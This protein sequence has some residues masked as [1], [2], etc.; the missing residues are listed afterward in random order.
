[1]ALLSGFEVTIDEV[2]VM[3]AASLAAFDARA[4]PAGWSI[5][6]PAQLG[7]GAQY[8]DGNYFKNGNS[9]ASAIVLQKGNEYIVSIRGSDDAADAGQVSKLADGTY[10]NFFKPLLNAVSAAAPTDAHFS[11]T[12]I[13]LGGGAVN[14]LANI[15]ASAYGG[16]FADATFVGFASPII[17]DKSG[18]VNFGFE[19]DPIFKKLG[20]YQSHT[21]SLDNLVLATDEYLAGNYDGRHPYSEDAHYKAQIGFEAIARLSQS[22]FYNRMS[23]DSLVIFAASNGIIQDQAPGRTIG[24]FYLGQDTADRIVGRSGSDFIEGFSGNDTL[25]GGAGNDQI[26]G[27]LGN[28]ALSGGLGIDTLDGG[29][30]NDRLLVT[31]TEAKSDRLFGGIGTD[32]LKVTGTADLT[33]A[34]FNATTSSIE[35]WQ[36]NGKAVLGDSA[37]NTFDFSGLKSVSGISYVDGGAGNDILVGSNFADVLRGGAGV[38]K[39]TGGGGNDTL[40]G[41]ADFDTFIFA[42]GFGK[43]RITDFTEG[44]GLNDVIQFDDAVF[45]NFNAVM[46]AAVQ[47]GANVEIRLD[48]NNVLTLNDVSLTGAHRLMADDFTFV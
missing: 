26:K 37:A 32:T 25:T 14:N 11:F 8:Q 9:G 10:I 48:A 42:A 4:V 28:D 36:G 30:G 15:A 6:T 24:A 2:N 23:P 47:V 19:N 45:A 41:G 38:D 22:E 40:T 1:M 43:D 34:K 3:S 18:I 13:S 20:N 44:S 12:G 5:V 21:S 35:I 17:N 29:G 39:L 33:L 31:G 46:A 16:R 27:G 7:L